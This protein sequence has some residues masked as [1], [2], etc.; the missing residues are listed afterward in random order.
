VH[1]CKAG[2]VIL[3]RQE[4]EDNFLYWTGKAW[5]AASAAFNGKPSRLE[6]PMPA[7]ETLVLDFPAGLAETTFKDIFGMPCSVQEASGQTRQVCSKIDLVLTAQSVSQS[8]S[9]SLQ[10]T[11]ETI[12]P[13]L[14]DNGLR[15][16]GGGSMHRQGHLAQASNLSETHHQQ[17]S[18][19]EAS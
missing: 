2:F 13:S 19:C 4:D 10:Y 3:T 9:Q 16:L 1:K 14:T 5:D 18:L 17:N 12:P 11:A 7:G 8:V 6:V 15:R